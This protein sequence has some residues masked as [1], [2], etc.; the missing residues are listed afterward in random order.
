MDLLFYCMRGGREGGGGGLRGE[1]RGE[2]T[3]ETATTDTPV[4]FS[5]FGLK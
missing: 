4:Y 5:P 3:F 1:G 2:A